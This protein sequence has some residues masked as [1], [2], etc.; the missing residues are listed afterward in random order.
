MSENKQF[1]YFAFISYKRD[2]EKWAK[3]LQKKLE[4]YGFPVALRKDNPSL[5]S[6]IRPIFRDQ[7]ELSGGNLKNEIEKGLEGSKYLIVICS[8]RA[9]KSP[10]VSKEVQYFIDNG[11]ENNIIPFIIGG[12]PNASNPEDECFPEGLR[13]LSGEKEI[14]GININEMGRDAAAIKVIARMFNLRFDTLWQRHERLKRR[15]RLLAIAGV[16]IFALLSFSVGAYMTY[17]NTQIAAQ[18]DRA[19]N[20]TKLANIQRNNAIAERIRANKERDRADSEKKRANKERNNALIANKFLKQAK[21]SI[22]LQSNLLAETNQDLELANHDLA[23]ERDNVI[24]AN[25]KI[26]ENLARAIAAKANQLIDDGD[27]YLAQVLCL[28]VLPENV[29]SNKKPIVP[30]IESALRRAYHDESGRICDDF[31]LIGDLFIPNTPYFIHPSS[32]DHKLKI[33]D[34]KTGGAVHTFPGLVGSVKGF[35]KDGKFAVLSSTK[36][37]YILVRTDSKEYIDTIDFTTFR[38]NNNKIQIGIVDN[39]CCKFRFCD[40]NNKLAI[41]LPSDKIIIYDIKSHKIDQVLHQGDVEDAVFLTDKYLVSVSN[42]YSHNC[43]IKKWG[44]NNGEVVDSII[45]PTG[46]ESQTIA[47]SPDN[48]NIITVKDKY[49]IGIY[50]ADDFTEIGCIYNGFDEH[51]NCIKFNNEGSFY[52]I[53]TANGKVILHSINDHIL[54]NSLYYGSGPISDIEFSADNNELFV[55]SGG[56]IQTFNIYP[57]FT[58]QE[59]NE[60]KW[61]NRPFCI[62]A[63]PNFD[64]VVIG[65]QTGNL[66]VYNYNGNNKDKLAKNFGSLIPSVAITKDGSKVVCVSQNSNTTISKIYN[67]QLRVLDATNLTELQKIDFQS[68][69]IP[70]RDLLISPDDKNVAVITKNGIEIFDLNTLSL[71]RKIDIEARK[72]DYNSDGTDIIS[73]DRDNHIFIWDANNGQCIESLYLPELSG[74]IHAIK[75]NNTS[76]K[77]AVALDKEALIIDL[78]HGNRLT[79]LQGHSN[80]IWSICFN[81]KGNLLATY[82]QDNTIKIWDSET[83]VCINTLESKGGPINDIVFD[84]N[85]QNIISCSED[86]FIVNWRLQPLQEVINSVRKRFQDRKLSLEEKR[87]YYLE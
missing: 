35:S 38:F 47:L 74:S 30:E 61:C 11:R 45:L 79:R 13:Q 58:K 28:E 7:S 48:N 25:W 26:Q 4:T 83:G 72:I 23:E 78:E 19:E 53:G 6:K 8:P 65:S 46:S 12:N 82:S 24:K 1:N 80:S 71:K 69:F 66:E 15:R 64:N 18:R 9:A 76:S 44:L 77:I 34:A 55:F 16:L 40:R 10:W 54:D 50:N 17:L 57:Q 86:G 84:Q 59:I 73:I 42:S 27:S 68:K 51:I 87:K 81:Q 62:A 2:D 63:T 43:Y 52:A 33:W 56:K 21:D 22:Q 41:I 36:N 49:K 32:D 60:I 67:N 70:I 3:W 5:P 14:L 85:G 31:C 39:A 29:N 20:Q 75:I 37:K